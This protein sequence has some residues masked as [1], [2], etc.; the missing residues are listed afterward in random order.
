MSSRTPLRVSGLLQT[1]KVTVAPNIDHRDDFGTMKGSAHDDAPTLITGTQKILLSLID[2]SPFQP[3]SLYDPVEIDNLAH[4]LAAAGQEEPIKLRPKADSRYEIV[5]SG[6][7]RVRAA[8][9]LGWIDIEAIIVTRTDREAKLATMVSNESRVDLTDFERGKLY[10]E[11]IACEFAK[12]QADVANLF[13]TS[14]ALVSKRL[15]MLKLPNN[16]I[17]MLEKRPDLFSVTCA[18]SITQLLKEY[19][20]ETPLIEAAVLRISEEGADQNSVKQWVQQMVRQK[21]NISHP[22]NNAV[23][24][25]QAGRAMFIAKCS[26]R[27]VT[28]RIKASEIDAKEVEEIVL[29]ALRQ[30]A[31]K[32]SA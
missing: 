4:T 10:Q 2:D 24:T 5:G 28:I 8:R 14:Q 1:G 19:P 6:H 18:E 12:T 22:Q 23:V 27:E 15:A 31:E 25:D 11:A 3:R 16:Y 17:A 30:R 13:G 29:A 21:H 26:G 9:S 20:D 32:T 7:R